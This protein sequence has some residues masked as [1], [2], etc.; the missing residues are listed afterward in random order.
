[1]HFKSTCQF[2]KGPH[3]L[4]VSPR[5]PPPPPPSRK[6]SCGHGPASSMHIKPPPPCSKDHLHITLLPPMRD[7]GGGHSHNLPPWRRSSLEGGGGGTEGSTEG[8]YPLANYR[9]CFSG[10]S[11]HEFSLTA[12]YFMELQTTAI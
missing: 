12:P 8:S 11:I 6:K 7:Q 2:S 5:H 10:L 9:P 1:M 4:T 3:L